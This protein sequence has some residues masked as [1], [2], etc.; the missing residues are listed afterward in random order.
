[1]NKLQRFALENIYCAPGQD[2]QFSFSLVRVNK[3]YQPVTSVVNVYNVT[4]RLPN[5]QYRYHVFVIGNLHPQLLNLLRQGKDWFRDVWVK[6]SDDMVL[7][8]YVMKIYNDKGVVYPR[9]HIYYSFI[10]E[11][12][13]V[14]ALEFEYTLKQ[15]FDVNSFKYMHVYSNSWFASSEFMTTE[16]QNGIKH[17]FGFVFNNAK[18]FKYYFLLIHCNSFILQI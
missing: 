2:Q 4:K 8:N 7:R 12:S 16:V 15:A 13:I 17:G 18:V 10:D 1:M 11:N 6:V 9:Q 14:I 3:V 5:T